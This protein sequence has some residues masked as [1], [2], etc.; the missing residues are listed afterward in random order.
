[1]RI[2]IAK[3]SVD[4]DY[5]MNET[6]KYEARQAIMPY[7][8]MSQKTVNKLI[9]TVPDRIKVT[10]RG[11]YEFDDYMILINANLNFGEVDIR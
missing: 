11:V 10:D 1:M 9:E 2:N 3:T 8:I 4:A 7:L 6:E 5:L